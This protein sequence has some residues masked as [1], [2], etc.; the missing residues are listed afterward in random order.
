M[1]CYHAKKPR[2]APYNTQRAPRSTTKPPTAILPGLL[3]PASALPVVPFVA[4]W[5][6]FGRPVLVVTPLVVDVA[7][8]CVELE[9]VEVGRVEEEVDVIGSVPVGNPGPRSVIVVT[10]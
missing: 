10:E 5:F 3:G 2:K 4:F 6:P 1:S 7:S 9:W 8:D